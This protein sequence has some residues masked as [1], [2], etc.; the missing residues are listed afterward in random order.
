MNAQKQIEAIYPLSPM[1]EGM[2]FHSLF[3]EETGVYFEQLCCRI[4]GD[5]EPGA[6]REAWKQLFQRHAVLR[7]CFMWERRVKPLQ[8]VR[9]EVEFSM[10]EEDWSSLPSV[11]AIVRLEKF[12]ADDIAAGFDL[13]RAPLMRVSLLRRGTREFTLIWSFHHILL[14]GWCVPRIFGELF[15]SYEGIV[16]GN[17]LVLP[18][19]RPYRDY[20][21][22]LQRQDLAKAERFWRR[23]LA[24]FIAPTSVR[25]LLTPPLE[26]QHNYGERVASLS[27]DQTAQTLAFIRRERLTMN[28]VVQGAFGLLLSRYSGENDI[29]FGNTVAGR[30]PD[31]RGAEEMVGVFINTL[32][33][34]VKTQAPTTIRP[35]LIDL[36]QRQVETRAFEFSPLS[37]IQGWSPVAKGQP[38]FQSI[39][40]FENYPVS[41]ALTETSCKNLQIDRVS[42]TEKT[43][44]P[45]TLS[46]AYA[47]RL[48]Y[49]ASY[50]R[51][52]YGDYQIEAMLQDLT[53]VIM[54]LVSEPDGTLG[55]IVLIEPSL[56]SEI[57]GLEE[58]LNFAGRVE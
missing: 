36:Q 32:P 29:I 31:L 16:T 47:D 19:V 56:E 15:R 3:A 8:V 4:V 21:A 49:Q 14:D 18:S 24:G 6:L 39:L 34:R 11:V 26:E 27:E 46:V 2:L 22:W 28:T 30:P 33:V 25:K 5:L 20:I 57:D 43:N 7:S 23:E 53:S 12:L 44:Y 10:L 40:V 55:D 9:K 41:H 50:D 51:R 1:Q 58:S 54:H 37:Q 42:M 13:S 17:P 35:W 45:L 52:A 48:M 38:L